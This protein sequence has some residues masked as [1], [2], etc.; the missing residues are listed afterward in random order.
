MELYNNIKKALSK[1][2][3]NVVVGD[4]YD[5]MAIWNEWYSGS[6]KDFHFYNVKMADGKTVE[7]ERRTLNMPK[8]VCEDF[9]KLEWSEKVEIKLDT[10]KSTEKLMNVLDSKENAF[11]VNFPMFLEKEYALGTMVTVEYKKDDKTLIDYIDGDVVLPYKYSNGYINGI[12]TVSR[13]VEE[14]GKKK[15]Y[16]NL[17]T[18]HEY[19]NG[20]YKTL[21]ELYV[22]KEEKE[23]G[24]EINF[25]SIYPD[26]KEFEQIVTE[27]PRFQ[28]WK[29][30]IANNLD[31]GSPFGISILAN[32]LDKFKNIDIKYDSFNHEF[33][34]GKRRVLIDKTAL[35][36][37]VKGV[38]ENG[39]PIMVSYFDTDDEVYV[40]IKGMEN[41]P[42]KDINFDL[43]VQPHIDAINT[44]LNYLSAGVG[45]GNGFYQFDKTGLKTATE[46]VSENSDTYR[47]MVHHRIPI[48][49]CLYD[50]I[51][52]IC[53]MENIPYNE[54]SINLDD[55]IIEDT[56]NIRKQALTE[57]NAKLI[58]KAEYFRKTDKLE[59]ESAIDYVN[60][61]NEEIQNQEIVDGSEFDLKE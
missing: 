60:K 25:K 31:T 1:K 48:Y 5:Y 13:S 14:E 50:L 35:K 52:T 15:K 28:V 49:D 55:S 7:K 32:Q 36:G 11:S 27:H 61:M 18:Y 43:R 8:K 20:V 59:E 41:Q 40:A 54:I 34:T 22:S 46:V 19:E 47:T 30:P 37:E 51:A 45:L 9:S 58:S 23:L 26:V 24:E 4:I 21:K 29:L 44:E 6:V 39:K 3:I 12:I 17:L 38:D 2:N 10:N 42:V 16:Y 56:D 57:Y 33:V 53:E